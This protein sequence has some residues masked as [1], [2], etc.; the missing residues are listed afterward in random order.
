MAP[1]VRLPPSP[2]TPTSSSWWT[3]WPPADAPGGGGGGRRVASGGVTTTVTTRKAERLM[4]LVICLLVT[5][6]Y[7]S[8]DR[9]R[10][11]VDGYRD[12]T[13]D[14]FEKMFERDKEELREIGI[15]IE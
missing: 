5:R 12:Q 3:S 6:G 1:P 4:N 9:I 8:K 15:P 10:K 7:V 2:R 11:V 13:P 14:A